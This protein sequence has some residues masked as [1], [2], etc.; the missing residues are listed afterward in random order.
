MVKEKKVELV[1]KYINIWF[2]QIW[3]IIWLIWRLQ[4]VF[5]NWDIWEKALPIVK[6]IW[7]S[8]VMFSYMFN[9]RECYI[10]LEYANIH[11]VL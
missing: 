7:C 3:L 1:T 4:F 11:C 9:F 10:S 6:D 2:T 8:F 5:Q